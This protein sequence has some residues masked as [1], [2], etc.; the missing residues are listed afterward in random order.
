MRVW[1]FL[2]PDNRWYASIARE[3]IALDWT[4]GADWHVVRDSVADDYPL[5]DIVVDILS[6]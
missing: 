5:A 1:L 6:R 4:R 3:C 2:A